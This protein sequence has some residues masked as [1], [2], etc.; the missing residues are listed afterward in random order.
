M[1]LLKVKVIPS[2]GPKAIERSKLKTCIYFVVNLSAYECAILLESYMHRENE[3][4][5]MKSGLRAQHGCHA[6][7]C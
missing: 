5:F 7:K 6:Y 1:R 4:L 3:I 2:S